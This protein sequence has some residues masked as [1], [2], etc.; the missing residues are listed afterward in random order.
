[1]RALLIAL[2]D[3]LFYSNVWIALAAVGMAAQTQFLLLGKGEPTALLG[4]IF[5]AT[6]FL[7]AVHRIIGLKKS[8]PFANTGRYAVIARFRS[9]IVFYAGMAG[10]C[11]ALFL[12]QMPLFLIAGLVAP[13]LLALLYV[14]PVWKGYRLRDLHYVKIFLI[15]IT[16]SW[17]TVF[18]VGLELG[19]TWSTPLYVMLLE[20]ALFVFAITIPFDIRDMEIDAFNKVKTLPATLGLR[21]SQRLAGLSLALML[22]LSALNYYWDV[23]T[24]GDFVALVLS[25]C[26]SGMLIFLSDRTRHDYFFTGLIDGMML[27]Q[28]LLVA[29]L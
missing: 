13:C 5:F 8:E 12:F 11:A 20:R 26:L 3:L 24:L 14:L 15:A 6:L 17:I 28:F 2:L 1:M 18:L 21:K 19:M 27:L 22:L 25:A 4:F 10:L 9:H 7:Y 16:W 29:F 23:Y